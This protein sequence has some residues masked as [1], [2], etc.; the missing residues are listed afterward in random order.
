VQ[1][2]DVRQLAAELYSAPQLSL[3]GVGP[4]EDVFLAAIEPL[5]A[6]ASRQ[7]GNDEAARAGARPPQAAAAAT[8]H[9]ARR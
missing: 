7:P 6:S 3:A 1:L 8:G 5:S 4:D 2:D 9:H